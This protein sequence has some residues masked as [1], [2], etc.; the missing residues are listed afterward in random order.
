MSA[1]SPPPA[2]PR[3]PEPSSAP[4]RPLRRRRRFVFVVL[5]AIVVVLVVLGLTTG[6]VTDVRHLIGGIPKTVEHLFVV[7]GYLIVFLAVLGE[8]AGMPLPGETILLIAGVAAPHGSLVLPSSGFWAPPPRSS[9]TTSAI[10]WA[11]TA[12]G[13][14]WCATGASCAC[15][16]GSCVILDKY[17]EVHGA[18]TVFLGRWV[19]F[20][21]VWAALFAGAARM[22]WKR[23]SS[24]TR[25]VA[26]PGSYSMGSLAYIFSSSIS[27]LKGVFGVLAWVLAI[28]V[29]VLVIVFVARE[30]RKSLEKYALEDEEA[31]RAA[32]AAGEGTATGDRPNGSAGDPPARDVPDAIGPEAA[33]GGDAQSGRA[34]PT[35]EA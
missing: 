26:P 32:Q 25:W 13:R 20:L 30:Q 15:R 1:A 11:T 31:Q 24:R 19:I 21:R 2:A 22:E 7:Y 3:T 33:G 35:H 6:L 16:R 17:F 29:G 4:R 14:C 8:S 18:K 5:V 34:Q 27:R 12:A 28:V 10:W 23:S 9:A